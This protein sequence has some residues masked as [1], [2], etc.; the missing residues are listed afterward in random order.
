MGRESECGQCR[1]SG[2]AGDGAGE[3]Q[4]CGVADNAGENLGRCGKT[5]SVLKVAQVK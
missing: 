4:D 2:S 5:V 1:A 3:M